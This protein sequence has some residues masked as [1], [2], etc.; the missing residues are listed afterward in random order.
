METRTR[1]LGEEHPDT[2]TSMN[3]LA[4]TLKGQGLTNK[5]I[6]LMED[7]CGLQTVVLGPQHPFTISSRE[8]LAT[9]QLEAI[10]ISKQSNA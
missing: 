3:N 8:T 5:A 2:L 9:W 6:S 1:V 4:F 7:G 10:E